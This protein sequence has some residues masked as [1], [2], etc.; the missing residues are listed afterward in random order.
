MKRRKGSWVTNGLAISLALGTVLAATTIIIPVIE[1][2]A[3]VASKPECLDSA[4][5]NFETSL[6]GNLSG[7]TVS[8]IGP[9]CASKW[10]RLSLFSTADGTGTP[11]EQIVW[12]MPAATTPPVTSYTAQ[13]NGSTT[14][15]VSSIV[16]PNN[17][18]G[19]AG[20]SQTL[21]ASSTVNSFNLETSDDALVDGP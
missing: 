6:Q 5:V 14:G 8:G 2:G 9:D 12:Q 13:A 20:L 10:V 21:I 19:A 16:W 3:G 15:V 17:E 7:V 1:L 4:V 18:T 11:V